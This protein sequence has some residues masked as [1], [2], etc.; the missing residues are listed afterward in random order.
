MALL[1]RFSSRAVASRS[2]EFL[3]QR[4]PL[5]LS[6]NPLQLHIHSRTAATAAGHLAVAQQQASPQ[7]LACYGFAASTDAQPSRVGVEDVRLVIKTGNIR[8]A[9]AHDDV[10]AASQHS[11]HIPPRHPYCTLHVSHCCRSCGL[12][13]MVLNSS[14]GGPCLKCCS[15]P[16]LHSMHMHSCT[17]CT[18]HTHPLLSHLS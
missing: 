2:S 5:L 1:L 16:Q 12:A 15:R 9:G 4:L 8:G 3:R 7:F 14:A 11:M 18:P 13:A 6:N 17:P 10:V